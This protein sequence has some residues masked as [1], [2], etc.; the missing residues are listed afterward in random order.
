MS[1]HRPSV[2]MHP[3]GDRPRLTALATVAA[4]VVLHALGTG[5]ALAAPPASLDGVSAWAETRDAVSITLSAI[6][7]AALALAV[8]QVV[9]LTIGTAARRLRR[10]H[11]SALADAWTLPALRRTAAAA[12]GMMLTTSTLSGAAGAA[13][14]PGPGPGG[15]RV[16]PTGVVVLSEQPT[17][18]G[19]DADPPATVVLQVVPAPGSPS[20]SVDSSPTTDAPPTTAGT[21]ITPL[22][23]P[24]P[25]APSGGPP[26]VEVGPGASAGADA[27]PPSPTPPVEAPADAA[28]EAGDQRH[29][30]VPGDHLWGLAEREVGRRLGRPPTEAETTN[31]WYVVLAANPQ[32]AD[33]DLLF[34]GDVVT[35][36]GS[37]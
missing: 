36:P 33:P 6:R 18:A 1:A 11:L 14:E 35:L 34:P 30:V 32:F 31:Y 7:L 37:A 25:A 23:D 12:V 8:Q 16:A 5:D 10:P 2:R 9:V 27:S 28:A 26:T 20:P 3:I 15:S 17:G 4:A 13:P 22:D 19:L 24:H 21:T 29:E